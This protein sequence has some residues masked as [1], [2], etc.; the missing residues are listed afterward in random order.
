MGT[1]LLHTQLITP[2]SPAVVLLHGLFGMS[3]NLMGTARAVAAEMPN[4]RIIVPDLINHG[5][6]P[7][8]GGMSY[9][10]MA[11]DVLALMDAQAVASAHIVGHSMGG[12]VAMQ[13]AM[14]APERVR[15]LTVVDIAPVAYPPRHT[16]ILQA[17]QV[18][19]EA[20]IQRRQEADAILAKYVPEPALR[21]FF[22]KNMARNE[23]GAW[24][25]RFG[26][27][28]ITNAY[29]SICDA[30][31]FVQPF[32]GSTLFIKGELSDYIL[33]E[34]SAVIQQFFPQAEFSVIADAGHWL[35]A[36]QPL[37]FHRQVLRFIEACENA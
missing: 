9:V 4:C 21:Q 36:E 30:P 20:D 25:W 32:Q 19:A 22:M 35:H 24:C 5:H 16:D 31:I 3:D 13:L 34:H 1:T 8:R 11:A 23:E 29:E 18:V 7:H 12:K 37:L 6:S 26:L 33:D 17:M 27:N 15:S 14:Q 28:E 2:Q 10:E